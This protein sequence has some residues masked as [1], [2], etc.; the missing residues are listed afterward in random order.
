MIF[1]MKHYKMKDWKT[2]KIYAEKCFNETDL[3]LCMV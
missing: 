1:F 3:S 2:L